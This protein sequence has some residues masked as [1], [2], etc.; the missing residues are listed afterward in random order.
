MPRTARSNQIVGETLRWSF[1][2]GPT[3]GSAFDHEF[4]KDGTVSWHDAGA[5]TKGSDDK[6]GDAKGEKAKYAAFDVG[7]DVVLVS[8]LAKSGFTLT[9]AMNF[10]DKSLAGV[11]SNDKQWFPVKGSFEVAKD[12][13]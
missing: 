6:K 13:A 2:D 3:A 11:A 12:A 4:G 8:Y 5:K 7:D 10:E 9:V 1:S